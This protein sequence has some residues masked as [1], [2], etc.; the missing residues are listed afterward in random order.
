M[1]KAGLK[2]LL[3]LTSLWLLAGPLAVLQLGAWTWM[4]ASY[5]QESS[6][7]QAVEETFSGERPCAMCCMITEV[8][9]TE[10]QEAPEPQRTKAKDLKLILGLGAAIPSPQ[11]C[12]GSLDTADPSQK[13]TNAFQAVPTPPPRSLT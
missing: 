12:I 13:Y 6:L 9:E 7:Q 8:E 5:S 2:S 11:R 1:F 4:I 10:Q 3:V